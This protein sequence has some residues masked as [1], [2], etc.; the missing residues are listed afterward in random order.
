MDIWHV[1]ECEEFV[2]GDKCRLREL[3]HPEKQPLELRYSLAHAT[4]DPGASAAP[5][6][7]NG[8]SEVYY[9][10]EGEGLMH[11]GDETAKV[12][13]G[14]A[15]YIPPGSTQYIEN[16]S[17]KPL[18]FICIVDPAWKAENEEIL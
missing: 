8:L 4:V 1:E 3:F 7:L 5:H 16:R 18:V 15:V 11:I 6:K 10:T 12:T 2:S 14:H 9:I 13:A 17:D